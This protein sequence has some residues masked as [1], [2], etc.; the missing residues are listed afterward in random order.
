MILYC[1]TSVLI[2]LYLREE[3]SDLMLA[4]AN[5][6]SVVSVCRITWTETMAALSR[7][8]RDV[9]VDG[10]VI[11]QARLRLQA[12]WSRFAIVEV[13]Q[14]LVE[15]A[16]EHADTFVL[17]GY[18]S[19]QLAAACVLHVKAKEVVTFACFDKRLRKA[20]KLLGIPTLGD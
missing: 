3:Q 20:A 4:E 18:D 9:Y 12:H 7:R 11:E 14:N 1:D 15:L 8:A 13:N 10:K 19:V 6:A 2:K 5:A 16:G 17:R